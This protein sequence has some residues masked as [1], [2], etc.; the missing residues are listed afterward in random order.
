[1]AN[2]AIQT[3]DAGPLEDFLFATSLVAGDHIDGTRVSIIDRDIV[4][5]TDSV[6]VE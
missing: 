3:A 4:V 6:L 2:P 1:M 5:E